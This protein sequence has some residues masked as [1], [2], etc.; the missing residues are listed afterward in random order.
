MAENKVISLVPR[1]E[2]DAKGKLEVICRALAD[3]A[4]MNDVE[5]VVILGRAKDGG[6]RSQIPVTVRDRIWWVGALDNMKSGINEAINDEATDYYD[7]EVPELA[8]V[9]GL[10]TEEKGEGD[11]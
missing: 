10:N 2:S 8:G 11:E 4:K 9:E 6:L 7:P 5:E 3:W 1:T